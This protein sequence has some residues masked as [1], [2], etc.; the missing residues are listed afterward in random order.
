MCIYILLIYII[1][2]YIYIY[3]YQYVKENWTM[4]KCEEPMIVVMFQNIFRTRPM[5][6]CQEFRTKI[7]HDWA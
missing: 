6:F 4:N 2:I 7:G 5:I 1:Y 3:R